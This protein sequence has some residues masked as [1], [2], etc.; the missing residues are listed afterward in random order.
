MVAKTLGI[1]CSKRCELLLALTYLRA[2]DSLLAVAHR[3]A[4]DSSFS[5]IELAKALQSV[6]SVEGEKLAK[7]TLKEAGIRL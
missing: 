2:K 4:N 7:L 5:A 3:I 6:S 1:H